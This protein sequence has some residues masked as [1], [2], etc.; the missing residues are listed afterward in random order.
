MNISSV[1]KI[2]FKLGEFQMSWRALI[3]AGRRRRNAK[4]AFTQFEVPQSG[5]IK[6]G[7]SVLKEKN[8]G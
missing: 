4:W 7:F 6:E 8:N 3:L 1:N 2:F 5:K